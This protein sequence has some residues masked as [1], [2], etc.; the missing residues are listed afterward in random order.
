MSRAIDGWE[1]ALTR[2]RIVREMATLEMAAAY[3]ALADEWA[4]RG[5]HERAARCAAKAKECERDVYGDDGNG[6]A[7][8]GAEGDAAI[9]AVG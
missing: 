2:L 6:R 9:D 3:S 7:N 5:D 1:A 4:A 8:A